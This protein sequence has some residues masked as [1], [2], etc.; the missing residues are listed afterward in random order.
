MITKINAYKT[1]DGA[2][3]PTLEDAQKAE[4]YSLLVT[5]ND[6]TDLAAHLLAS[7]DRLLDILTT[8]PDSRPKAR[9]VNGGTKNRTPKIVNAAERTEAA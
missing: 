2:A 7:K 5:C 1:S 6:I 9:K 3:H 4:L 8:T